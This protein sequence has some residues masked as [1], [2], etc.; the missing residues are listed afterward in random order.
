MSDYRNLETGELTTADDP[1]RGVW[2]AAATTCGYWTDDW[3]K[4]QTLASGI[5]CCPCCHSVGLQIS[6]EKWFEIDQGVIAQNPRYD[7]WLM[8][9]KEKCGRGEGK[10]FIDRY[11]EW[12]M[13]A[14]S[15]EVRNE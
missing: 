7:E 11:E 13:A 6:A 8:I 15:A 12:Y 2:Y 10:S 9:A 1:Q 5:P 14:R 3:S 4:L